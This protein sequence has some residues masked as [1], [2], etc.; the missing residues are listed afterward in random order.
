MK[1]LILA[2]GYG[3][4]LRPITHLMPKAMVPLCN[5]PLIAWASDSLV[6]A[7]VRELI[8]NLHHFPQPIERFMRTEYAGLTLHFS[9]EREILGT[10]GAVRRVR[11]LLDPGE[12]FFLVNA[13]TIQSPPLDRLMTARREHDALAALTLRHPPG[14]DRFTPVWFEDPFITGFGDGSG[15]ALMFS[16]SQCISSRIF[17]SLPDKDFSGIVD[18]AYQPAMTRGERL[19]G[20]VDDGLWFDI[21]TPQRYLSAN[22]GVRE[23][24]LA[25]EIAMPHGSGATGDSVVDFSSEIRVDLARSTVGARSVIDGRVSDSAIWDDCRIASGVLLDRCI[26]FHGVVIDRPLTLRDAIV[27]PATA[28]AITDEH[29]TIEQGLLIA[30]FR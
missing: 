28:G 10:G 17:Q 26:V 7:G 14:D 8:V 4:R 19:A 13:D 18:E 6:R 12:D 2:A 9:H 21:G 5:R 16:G 11:Q 20:V 22:S 25:G 3:T 1:A 27:C 24:M 29:Q 30:A 23:R 15:E